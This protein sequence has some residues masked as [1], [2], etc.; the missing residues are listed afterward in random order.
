MTKEKI[1]FSWSGGK[2]SALA[3][4][5]VQQSGEFEIAALI[6]TVA[7]EFDRICMHGVRRALLERQAEEIGAPLEIIW[8]PEQPSNVDYERIMGDL[9][10]RHE[11]RGVRRVAFGDIFLEDLRAYRE[12][13]LAKAG[14]SG[15]YPIWKRDS[16]HLIEAFVRD[17]FRA[18]L[19]CID[20][21]KVPEALAGAD[22]DGNFL[23]KVPAGVDPCGENG[24]FHSFVY[25]GPIFRRPIPIRNGELRR[26]PPFLYRDLIP[27][28]AASAAE[29]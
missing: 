17:G 7:V 11:A 10:A 23:A 15:I 2:D 27:V 3:L 8:M 18:R 5:A 19:S 12:R 13:M 1:L 14:M 6:T 16:R 9:L 4:H 28:E 24:E 26:A 29:R 25:E 20:A 21:T 22:I